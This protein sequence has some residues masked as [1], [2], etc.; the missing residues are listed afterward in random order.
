MTHLNPGDIPRGPPGKPLRLKTGN[1]LVELRKRCTLV[2]PPCA[3][4]VHLVSSPSVMVA[5]IHDGFLSDHH[6]RD[7]SSWYACFMPICFMHSTKS[8]THRVH[9]CSCMSILNQ[10]NTVSYYTSVRLAGHRHS[11]K[12]YCFTN[13]H[14]LCHRTVL[15]SN[16]IARVSIS[17]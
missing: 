11:H 14:S 9:I 13:T 10:P 16:I 2:G 4:W 3:E 5:T 17:L 6:H 12:P 7:S 15:R 1:T 8:L